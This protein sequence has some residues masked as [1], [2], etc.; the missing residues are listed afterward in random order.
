[1]GDQL[2]ALFEP[3]WY[4][5]AD[6]VYQP[7]SVRF[8]FKLEIETIVHFSD[9]ETLLSC[10]VLNDHLLKKQECTLVV[11]SLSD[12]N[13]RDP[14]VRCV[15]LFAIIALLVGDHVFNHEVLLQ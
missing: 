2:L 12:L 13:L 15:C 9:V 5:T 4:L 10:V 7:V 14:Q 3:G 6:E 11:N 8:V 1:V